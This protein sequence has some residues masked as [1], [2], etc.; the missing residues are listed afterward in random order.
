MEILVE[1]FEVRKNGDKV[2][3]GRTRNNKIVHVPCDRD[4]RGEFINVRI[5]N[6][7]T[8]YLNGELV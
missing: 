3:T 8:W 4:L 5:T 1:G 7:R 2:I 6:A